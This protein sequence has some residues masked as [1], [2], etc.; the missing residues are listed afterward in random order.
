MV[1]TVTLKRSAS[2]SAVTPVRRPRRY[3]ARAK[4]RSVRRIG[5]T[6][7]K[8]SAGGHNASVSIVANWLRIGRRRVNDASRPPDESG[9]TRAI[10]RG[11]S[12]QRD[13][14]AHTF[15][16]GTC[17]STVFKNGRAESRGLHEQ[18]YI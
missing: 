15:D 9:R 1:R 13:A 3:S 4:R 17:H 5:M 14:R 8:L 10:Q 7:I 12:R 2:A 6:D 11:I 16:L 18:Y